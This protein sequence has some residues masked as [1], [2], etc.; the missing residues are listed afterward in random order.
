MKIV[1]AGCDRNQHVPLLLA[2]PDSMERADDNDAYAA[3][4]MDL[5]L[6][7]ILFLVARQ[8]P[9]TALTNT[10]IVEETR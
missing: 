3:D 8:A 9:G 2:T 5:A 6:F 10:L 1:N 4:P 7:P